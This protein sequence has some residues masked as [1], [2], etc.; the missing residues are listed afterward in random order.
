[1]TIKPSILV[2]HD[3]TAGGASAFEAGVNLAKDLGAD[4]V[5]V[6]VFLPRQI[7]Q[8]DV[9]HVSYTELW[10]IEAMLELG[11]AHELTESW[12]NKAREQGLTVTTEV[13]EGKPSNVILEAAKRHGASVIVVGSGRHS[14]LRGKL[15]G[16]TAAHVLRHSDRPVL[17]APP[18]T[19]G[20]STRR[21]GP[22]PVRADPARKG[23][24]ITPARR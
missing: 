9:I 17:V 23:K 11:D 1:M 20:A 7:S 10:N 22:R 5:L 8:A 18:L 6:H 3:L 4:L 24:R 12:A 21:S 2:A 19:V 16:S 14:G 13:G 15:P